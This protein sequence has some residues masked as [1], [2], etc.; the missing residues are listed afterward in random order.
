MSAL[1]FWI[2]LSIVMD[3]TPYLTISRHLLAYNEVQAALLLLRSLMLVV[4]AFLVFI[5][6]LHS[7]YYLGMRSPLYRKRAPVH[8]WNRRFFISVALLCT[9][10]LCISWGLHAVLENVRIQE[11][12]RTTTM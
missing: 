8:G 1:I 11:S 5:A 9:V 7:F 12:I 4:I 6:I 3:I 10:F 2:I